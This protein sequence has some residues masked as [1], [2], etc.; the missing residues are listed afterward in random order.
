MSFVRGFF[1]NVAKAT[2]WRQSAVDFHGD[3]SYTLVGVIDCTYTNATVVMAD[4]RGREFKPSLKVH[5]SSPT[6]QEGDLLVIGKFS[7]VVPDENAK[8]VRIVSTA[9]PMFGPQDFDIF[10]E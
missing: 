6:V 1:D 5:T 2:A 9:S 10:V 7:G 4:R 8:P 3:T